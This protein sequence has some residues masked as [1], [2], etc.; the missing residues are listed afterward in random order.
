M[1]PNTLLILIIPLNR[2]EEPFF[3]YFLFTMPE[4]SVIIPTFNRATVLPRAVQSVL[5]QN[6]TDLELIV[7][8]DRSTDM[9]AGLPIL[10]SD[11]RIS[12]IE[13]SHNKGVSA[14]RNTG[15]E[16]ARGT[17]IAF[18]DSDD[19]WHKEK[20]RCQVEWLHVHPDFSICQTQEVWIR[21]GVRVNPPATH[22][23]TEGDIFAAS[24]QRC[25]ITPSSVM[26]A[27]SM[28]ETVGGFDETFPACE[29]YDLWLRISVRFPVGL[30]DRYL[31]TRYGG[32]PDQLS[33]TVTVLD[34]YRIRAL[35]KL[36]A[37]GVLDSTQRDL[38]I[39]TLTK[40]AIIVAQ[41]CKKRGKLDEYTY[42]HDLACRFG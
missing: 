8:D 31:L 9:T 10:Q 3:S 11:A 35:E 27:R 41:G 16:R 33:R 40:K 24:L 1:P 42:Y 23:K 37:S 2:L 13:H 5:D 22:R 26:I 25:M 15:I 4:I 34:R 28:F 32:H 18:L 12:F 6:Y 39:R 14:A 19:Q 38:V 21:D 36:L 7:V 30:V 20:L 29:D 17:W